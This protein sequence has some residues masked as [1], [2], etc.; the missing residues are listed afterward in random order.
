MS[1]L[2]I[3]L[4]RN[5][6]EFFNN[7]FNTNKKYSCRYTNFARFEQYAVKFAKKYSASWKAKVS[8]QLNNFVD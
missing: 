3:L 4:E 5:A 1:V 8:A 6:P 7:N 2:Y